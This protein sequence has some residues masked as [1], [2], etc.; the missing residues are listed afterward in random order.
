MDSCLYDEDSCT[1]GDMLMD[2]KNPGALEMIANKN[3]HGEMDEIMNVLN[4]RERFVVE[5]YYGFN[6]EKKSLT[7]ISKTLNISK[8]R[9]R[10]IRCAAEK[11]LHQEAEKK[12]MQ[13]YLVA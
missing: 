7:K 12:S 2:T 9:V 13:Y 4:E 6:G 10:Q 8:E 3:M 1:L 11:K 5:K